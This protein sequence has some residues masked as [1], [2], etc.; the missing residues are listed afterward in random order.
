MGVLKSLNRLAILGL[1]ACGGAW[2]QDTVSVTVGLSIPGPYFLVDGQNFTSTQ[3]FQWPVGS[4]HQ[5]YFVQTL[6]SDG[7]TLANHQ[8]PVN[9]PGSRYTFSSWDVAGQATSGNQPLL[10]ITV[11]PT[12]TQILGQVT[13]EDTAVRELQR[14]H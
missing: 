9:S 8:Y 4:V 11:G 14:V 7:I 13:T 1:L 6:E 12:L 2:A 3:I 10:I 5:I